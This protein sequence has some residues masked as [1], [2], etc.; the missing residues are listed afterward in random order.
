MKEEYQVIDARRSLTGREIL[1]DIYLPK[2][3]LAIEYQG[4]GH[5]KD[6]YALGNRWRQKQRDEEKRKICLENGI[7]LIEI[8]YW[9]N[10]KESTLIGTIREKRVDLLTLYMNID[11]SPIPT[12]PPTELV[13]G[14]L[15][16]N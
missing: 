7:T 16:G 1:L 5:F 14:K 15:W 2:E 11:Y 9:W 10:W 3:K 8:P 6:I 12:K 4:E 13:S